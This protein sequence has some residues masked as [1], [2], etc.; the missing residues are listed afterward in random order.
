MGLCV[1][2]FFSATFCCFVSLR[3]ARIPTFRIPYL[4]TPQVRKAVETNVSAT[5][6]MV[7]WRKPRCL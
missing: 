6:S 5:L 3:C 4:R 2:I 1:N 7:G